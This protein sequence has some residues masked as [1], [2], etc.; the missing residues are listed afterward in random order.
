MNVYDA[1][2]SLAKAIKESDE[3]EKFKS[4]QAQMFAKEDIKSQFD[5]FQKLQ[6][7]L[8]TAQMTGQSVDEAKMKEAQELFEIIQK[9]PVANQYFL[10]E[11]KLNQMMGD[12][13]KIISEAMG[14]E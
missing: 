5:T 8:Q 14:I 7:E 10:A 12:I 1:A 11:M 9:D 2:H 4:L 13:T 3:L 6:M